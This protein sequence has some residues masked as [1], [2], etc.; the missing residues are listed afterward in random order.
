MAKVVKRRWVSDVAP[1]LP[2]R[3]RRWC[4]YEAYLPDH[5]ANRPIR[6]AGE[7][8]ADV[9]D[10][11]TAVALFDQHAAALANTEALARLL[12]RAESVA[13][14]R[15][16]GLEV[17]GRRLL[18]AEAAHLL[19][20]EPRDVTAGEVLANIHAMTWALN[21][22]EEGDDI[23]VG[24]IVE[25]HR[26]LLAGTPSEKHGG[27][28]RGEQNWIGGSSY[29]PCSAT[30]VPPPHEHVE[31][32]LIDLCAFCNTDDLPVV[33]QAALAHAQ[34]ETIHPFVDGNGRVGRVLLQLVLRRRGLARRVVPPI[35]L[36]LATWSTDYVA[37]LTATRYLGNPASRAAFEGTNRWIGLFASACRRAIG[38]A[39]AFEDD[40]SALQSEWRARAG[41]M[42]AESAADLLIKALPGAPIVT[43]KGAADLIGRTFQATNA[44]IAR[45]VDARV[46]RQVDVGRRN[47]AFEAPEVIRRFT[48]LER[49][50]ASPG[51]DTRSSAPAR[52]IP[53]RP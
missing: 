48:D 40:V 27:R 14:S 13:S 31:D 22:V 24:T 52:R 25:A 34:F 38:D 44:A 16:E 18:R 33:T 49:R 26:R 10:A 37:G 36:V 7:V 23:T 39:Q 51:G 21:T 29:N 35:S 4:D 50:L 47:R 3:D 42:R 2:R 19:G 6:L 1:D 17:G 5:I 15:I 12:L 28:V 8:A 20:D 53:R 9:A 41:P 32:L 30:F 43:V 45:L 46:L 11:E